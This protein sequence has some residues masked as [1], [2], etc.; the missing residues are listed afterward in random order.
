MELTSQQRE[1]VNFRPDGD[2]LVK[3]IPGSGKSLTIVKRAALLSQL[4]DIWGADPDVPRVRVFTYNRVLKEWIGF[5]ARELGED[6]PLMT[7][8][9]SWA[10]AAMKE[11]RIKY[12]SNFDD[13]GA[14][15]LAAIEG[16][17]DLPK[18]FQSHHVLV[19]EGQDL[20][21]EA[22]QV[23]KRSALTS[24]TIAADK[25]Q[26]IYPT[27]FTWKSLGINVQGRSKSLSP[28]FRG[29]RQIA[30][31]AMDIIRNDP[32]VEAE[33]WIKQ[34][35]GVADGPM[36]EVYACGS[37]A[38]RDMVVE[39]IIR[40][41]RAANPRGTIAILHP[42]AKPI[43]AIAKGF[44]GRVL[45]NDNP[46]MV[47]PGVLASTI[48]RVKGLEFDTVII[49]DVNEGV[50]PPSES[51]DGVLKEDLEETFRRLFYVAVTRARRRLAILCDPGKRSRYVDE[52]DP[53]HFVAR[54]C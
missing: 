12:S 46:D 8:F 11:M 41:A 52:L 27:R 42:R 7:T 39:R 22:L 16:G 54:Q 36:P 18:A 23:L 45:D 37:W 48:H 50:L 15:L 13:D 19:D 30:A 53:Q 9:H 49:E 21:L 35:D 17:K 20:S 2:L 32:A 1:V 40:E 34:E 28:S 4:K 31:L 6:A 3:G 44:G 33:E 51:T 43:F 25:A 5:L 26:N 14:E 29:T 38:V 47:S 24:F 10:R